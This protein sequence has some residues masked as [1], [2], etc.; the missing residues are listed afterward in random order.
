MSL[1]ENLNTKLIKVENL[2]KDYGYG[3]GIFNVNIFVKQG[4]VLGFLGPNGAG[5][6]TTIRHLM[7]FS[8][9]H[10]GNCY[11]N[12]LSCF[13]NSRTIQKDLG[14]LPGEIALPENLTAIE[15]IQY[16]AKLR[17]VKNMDYTNYLI[18]L[19]KLDIKKNIKLK[20]MAL[21]ERRKLAIITAFM[22]DP[23]ILVLDEPTSGLDPIGQITFIEFIREEKKRGKTILLSSHLFREVEAVCDRISIIK[24]GMIVSECDVKDIK[25]R[26]KKTFIITFKTKEDWKRFKNESF[27]IIYEN[28]DFLQIKIF[29][30]DEETNKLINTLLKYNLSSFQ[31]Q[32][33]SLEDY[34]M[35]FYDRNNKEVK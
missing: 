4:E 7:G 14:Y 22:H 30:N 12:N 19:F 35:H 28:V 26:N 10:S 21:G 16:M 8:V 20:R 25:Y 5:K 6:T 27:N 3:R 11:V 13:D 33:Y 23:K 15:F 32:K 17:K 1:N 18:S 31:E 9:P 2:T 29:I 34:F 24:D